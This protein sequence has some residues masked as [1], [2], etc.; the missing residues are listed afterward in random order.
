MIY[1]AEPK[2]LQRRP[3]GVREGEAQP[4]GHVAPEDGG[5][6]GKAVN[7][8]N[9]LL[10]P[11]AEW[12]E[13]VH[14]LQQIQIYLSK[15]DSRGDV[16]SRRGGGRARLA[17]ARSGEGGAECGQLVARDAQSRR[18]LMAAKGIEVFG[19]FC[20]CGVD[21]VSGRAADGAAPDVAA[22]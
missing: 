7:L 21:V 11:F 9:W 4:L 16:E 6:S 22:R 2:P 20:Q 19:T 18:A 3:R 17:Q 1:R 10:V 14:G 15:G 13:R 8:E 12:R 5:L